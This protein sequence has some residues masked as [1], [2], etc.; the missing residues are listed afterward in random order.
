[1]VLTLYIYSID[2]VARNYA[3]VDIYYTGNVTLNQG[4]SL[5]KKVHFSYTLRNTS[6]TNTSYD[7]GSSMSNPNILDKITTTTDPGIVVKTYQF[8]YTV[9]KN[10]YFL[11]SV[12]EAGSDG[13]SFNP[14]VFNYGANKVTDDVTISSVFDNNNLPVGD[15]YAGDF[16]GDGKQDVL[17]ATISYDNDGLKH[18]SGYNIM[19]FTPLNPTPSLVYLNRYTTPYT[20]APDEVIGTKNGFYNFLTYDYDGDGKSD[21][22]MTKTQ[23]VTNSTGNK[24][25]VYNGIK[26]NYSKLFNNNN[27][28]DL[29][30]EAA[31]YNGIPT[32]SIYSQPFKYIHS[33]KNYFIPGDFDGDGSEDYILILGINNTN[34]FKAFFSCPKKGIFNQ[35]ITNFGVEGANDPFYATSVAS[36]KSLIPVDFDGDGKSEI[37]VI[38]DNQ[39]YILSV[40]PVSA[41]TGYNYAASVLYTTT[42]IKSGYPVFPGDFNG[43]RKTDL[44]VRTPPTSPFE[45]SPYGS[46]NVL[47]STGTVFNSTPL[48]VAL[49]CHQI[50]RVVHIVL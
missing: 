8:T 37:L 7:G 15:T 50:R 22:L 6:Q 30:N 31:Y 16:D 26:V 10:E 40:Y 17:A 21:V 12:Q 32:S 9:V 47:Y 14:T 20:E 11:S 19:G 42:A 38:K 1:M 2:N 25:W 45:S 18:N 27:S 41:S 48:H 3:L 39:S 43:D 23:L 29:S 5:Y 13:I 24:D 34:A 49:T 35:E 4:M 33:S 46:W 44:L 28:S 36:A